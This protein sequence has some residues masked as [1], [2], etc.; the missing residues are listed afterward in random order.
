MIKIILLVTGLIFATTAGSQAKTTVLVPYGDYMIVVPSKPGIYANAFAGSDL[1]EQIKTA[2]AALPNSSG[3]VKVASGTYS[4]TSGSIVIPSNITVVCDSGVVIEVGDSIRDMA[5]VSITNATNF[6]LE[7]CIVDGNRLTPTKSLGLIQLTDSSHGTLSGNVIRNSY[8]NGLYLSGGNTQIKITNNDIYNNG[9][10]LDS[11]QAG[12][13]IGSGSTGAAGNTYISI[14]Q[15]K[16]HD[17][18]IG[19]EIQPSL[20]ATTNFDISNN[21]IYSNA[22]D[23][24]LVFSVS[25]NGGPI[26]NFM[27]ASNQSYCNGWPANGVNFSPNCTPGFL[28]HGSVVSSSGVGIDLNSASFGQSTIT[29]NRTHDN[30]YEGIDV[31]PLTITQVNT[32]GTVVTAVSGDPFITSWKPNQAVIINGAHYLIASISGT[33]QM[34][35]TTSAGT[36]NMAPFLGVGNGQNTLSGNTSYNN[37]SGNNIA[38]GHGFG[39][40][41]NGDIWTNNVAYNNNGVGFIDQLSSNVSHTGD[42]AYNND[43]NGGFSTGFLCQGCLNAT[44]TNLTAYDS[45]AAKKQVYGL[46]L[47]SQADNARISTINMPQGGPPILDQGTNDVYTP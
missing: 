9:P 31:T 26:S 46:V 37:G 2:I 29:G 4:I 13:G 15:N 1:A 5:L 41:A 43:N 10:T 24:L 39:D 18:W 28:Q 40:I 32:N 47:D 11:G 36:Q 44:Y 22:N 27:I 38:S 12:L 14:D 30:F 17:N 20:T 16:V 3:I 21:E 33:T 45:R 6:A 7:N 42:T 8:G 35:L 19:I 23:G 34:T 25:M